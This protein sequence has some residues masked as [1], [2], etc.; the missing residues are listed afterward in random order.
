MPLKHRIVISII[1]GLVTVLL[2]WFVFFY[3]GSNSEIERYPKYVTE[4][5]DRL[6][7]RIEQLEK[8]TSKIMYSNSFQFRKDTIEV[9]L[10]SDKTE[11]KWYLRYLLPA[12]LTL[13]IGIISFFLSQI[14]MRSLDK[15]KAKIKYV[16][17]LKVLS[18]EIKRNLDL[19]CQLHA[20][21]YVDILPTFGLSFFITDKMFSE[22]TSV[23]LNYDL[24]KKI[25][26][27]YFEYHHIQNRL[28]ITIQSARDLE[29]VKGD[30]YELLLRK[31]RYASEKGGTY[32]LIQGNIKGSF[33][34]Y[35]EIIREIKKYD[36]VSKLSE[37]PSNY[38]EI[39]YYEFQKHPDVL[40]VIEHRLSKDYLEKR[41]KFF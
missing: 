2:G 34:I 12:L 21:L 35:N 7:N 31:N 6:E 24:L 28:D 15:K 38:L 22:L 1:I 40:S 13:L 9:K 37:L 14:Y 17:I 32:L 30:S 16:G 36:K 3:S 27:K 19:E 26:H 10:I 23:C 4:K 5:V 39:K 18:E 11:D 20:Y 8:D 41:D 29:N 33:E 25:F